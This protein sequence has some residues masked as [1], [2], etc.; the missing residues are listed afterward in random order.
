M[1]SDIPELEG[2]TPYEHVF[3]STPDISAMAMLDFYQP[4]Y[5]YMPQAD[6]PFKKELIG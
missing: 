5:Y 1:A 4:V 2:H 6:F 3:A